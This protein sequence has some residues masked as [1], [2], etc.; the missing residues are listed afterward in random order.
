MS[1]NSSARRSAASLEAVAKAEAASSTA[2]SLDVPIAAE[3]GSGSDAANASR[4]KSLT[5]ALTGT[6]A[7][8]VPVRLLACLIRCA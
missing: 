5:A 2:G 6:K 7:K 1:A 3:G 8:V 4:I